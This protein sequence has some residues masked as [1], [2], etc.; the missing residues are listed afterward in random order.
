VQKTPTISCLQKGA[1][2]VWQ[3][4]SE[5]GHLIQERS[6]MG[7]AGDQVL[8]NWLGAEIRDD[9]LDGMD[10]SRAQQMEQIVGWHRV[11]GLKVS[12][13]WAQVSR[14]VGMQRMHASGMH[15]LVHVVMLTQSYQGA[16]LTQK[17][18]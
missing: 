9:L 5:N 2:M 15:K 13:T 16:G 17:S 8:Q 12:D 3:E 10:S 7:W 18:K 1:V 4:Q 11:E 6:R 14:S